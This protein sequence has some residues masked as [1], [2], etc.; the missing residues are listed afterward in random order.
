MGKDIIEGIY[1][2]PH[3]T[4][5]ILMTIDKAINVDKVVNFLKANNIWAYVCT[6]QDYASRLYFLNGYIM[7][8]SPKNHDWFV[9]N[10][11]ENGQYI[12]TNENPNAYR[13]GHIDEICHPP[14]YPNPF[15][16]LIKIEKGLYIPGI[17][18]YMY[19]Y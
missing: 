13:M 3:T 12:P 14:F 7:L 2:K 11:G 5:K 19:N 15:S 6:K 18:F 9:K 10:L 8:Q 17:G 1:E 16:I 4:W